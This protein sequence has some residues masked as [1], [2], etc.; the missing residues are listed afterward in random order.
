MPCNSWL[1]SKSLW[2]M[3]Q[4]QMRDAKC[5][6]FKL[7][8]LKSAADSEA[9]L[10]RDRHGKSINFI[11]F[12]SDIYDVIYFRN[13]RHSLNL[14]QV[15][16]NDDKIIA[17]LSF[18]L[19]PAASNFRGESLKATNGIWSGALL[20]VSPSLSGSPLLII[21]DALPRKMTP[22]PPSSEFAKTTLCGKNAREK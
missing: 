18:G 19:C 20:G 22:P 14:F 4:I 9:K 5:L 17:P 13:W 3:K 11:P 2:L 12:V 10:L 21:S 7:N 8:C 15:S 16:F 1:G 6:K